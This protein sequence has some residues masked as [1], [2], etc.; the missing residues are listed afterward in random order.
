MITAIDHGLVRELRLN[1]PPANALTPALIAELRRSVEEAPRDAQALVLSGSPGMFSAGLDVPV[2]L[3]IDRPAMAEMWLGFYALLESLARSPIPIAAAITGHAPAGG[4]VIVLFCDWR[5]MAQGDWKVG[6]NEVQVGLTLPPV[7]FQAFRRQVGLRESS[8]AVR[9]LLCSAAEAERI[10]LGEELASPAHV[11]E[12]A[13]E[14]C[15]SILALPRQAMLA[16]RAQARADL[17][18]LFS[19]SLDREVDGIVEM[20][21]SPGVQ[22]A[23]R[24]FAEKLKKKK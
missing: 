1:H 20:W 5:V 24:T 22:S 4:T 12:R 8:R 3:N 7:V 23:L 11:V 17:I 6:L 19:E 9:G 10:G 21:W 14:W 15:Q 18:G 16:T 13:L 2:L